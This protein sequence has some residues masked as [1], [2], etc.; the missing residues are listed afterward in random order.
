[1][2]TTLTYL[3]YINLLREETTRT[4]TIREQVMQ[5][6]GKALNHYSEYMHNLFLKQSPLSAK[7]TNLQ[8]QSVK[9][10]F[11]EAV[12]NGMRLYTCV[13]EHNRTRIA[14]QPNLDVDRLYGA[15]IADES[16]RNKLLNRYNV[17]PVIDKFEEFLFLDYIEKNQEIQDYPFR[18]VQQ[19]RLSTFYAVRDA[20]LLCIGG[21]E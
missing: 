19:I 3:D 8:S 2:A 6:C 10:L 21:C 4:E 12:F 1:M 5:N 13:A 11:Q 15:F 17:I 20:Y 7:I 9:E 14:R 18:E 16:T